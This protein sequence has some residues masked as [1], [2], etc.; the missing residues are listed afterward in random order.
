ME[1]TSMISWAMHQATG[2]KNPPA[3]RVMLCEHPR[4]MQKKSVRQGQTEKGN[5]QES[6]EKGQSYS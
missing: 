6:G 5:P 2:A 3:A 4:R 1:R